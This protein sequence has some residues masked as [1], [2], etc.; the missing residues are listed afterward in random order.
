MDGIKVAMEVHLLSEGLMT[1]RALE[2]TDAR[3]GEEVAAEGPAVLQP[4]MTL[5]TLDPT[6]LVDPSRCHTALE[7][8]FRT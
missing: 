3:V 1:L 7:F 8:N 2:W 5:L 6:L 4:E